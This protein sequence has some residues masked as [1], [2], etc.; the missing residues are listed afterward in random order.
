VAVSAL[1]WRVV[2]MVR[3]EFLVGVF[4]GHIGHGRGHYRRRER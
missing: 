2:V 3:N 1:T 4:D